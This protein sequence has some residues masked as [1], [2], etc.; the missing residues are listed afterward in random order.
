M[1]IHGSSFR[2]PL[3]DN[4]VHCAITSPPYW[5]LR[6]YGLAPM[7]FGGRADCRHVWDTVVKHRS[8][9]GP[10]VEDSKSGKAVTSVAQAQQDSVSQFC[11]LCGA[12][13][14]SFGL[15]P[16]LALHVQNAV[17]VCREIKRVLRPDGTLWLNYG[18]SF[19]TSRN[20]R[21]A[22]DGKATGNDDRT[23]RDKPFS[24][25]G[26]V[27]AKSL[28]G[29]PWRV[30]LA[31]MDDG[32]I[33]RAAPQWV[34]RNAMPESVQDRPGNAH[35]YVF[36]LTKSERYFY[37]ISAVRRGK[38]DTETVRR[39]NTSKYPKGFTDETVFKV[40]GRETRRLLQQEQQFS[41]RTALSVQDMRIGVRQEICEDGERGGGKEGQ[42]QEIQSQRARKRILSDIQQIGQDERD[43]E[44]IQSDPRRSSLPRAIQKIGQEESGTK[45]VLR[46]REGS[47]SDRQVSSNRKGAREFAT[48]GTQASGK[49]EEY[50]KRLDDRAMEGNTREARGQVCDMRERGEANQG[51]YYPPEQGGAS[52]SQQYSGPL[53]ELQQQERRQ[54]E[55]GRALRTSD[56]FFDS[57]DAYIAHLQDIRDNGGLLLDSSG[58]P[59]AFVINPQPYKYA[60][61][62]T[63]PPALIA[64]MIRASTSQKGV[65]PKCGAPWIRVKEPT[66]EY[67]ELLGK[68]WAD[69]DADATE[70]RGHSV[71]NQRPVKRNGASVTA[72]YKTTG[73]KPSCNCADNTPIPAVILDPFCGSGTTGFVAGQLSRRFI[74]IDLSARYLAEN[75]LPRSEGLT[76]LSTLKNIPAPDAQLALFTEAA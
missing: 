44:A 33:L 11:Q 47:G 66:P 34:K 59:D 2:L 49:D 15:E 53:P 27:R 14:G 38:V 50:S 37:D 45:E 25:V 13:L 8:S 42:Q 56:F 76:S 35:E 58:N 61:Y 29:I 40:Q 31:L 9:G 16:T 22:A 5:G 36:M 63:F 70:G 72:A 10:Q 12:W 67:A 26:E 62:A 46:E 48:G 1:L 18:D 65:C 24:T 23:F 4:S 3:A 20:G 71:S 57:L 39:H 64:P 51:S 55:S 21:S 60:H 6:D 74:G 43:T 30:V 52:Y 7:I 28:C 73:W 41:E 19:A 32:W 68:D 69:Y 75:A 54:I 17:L